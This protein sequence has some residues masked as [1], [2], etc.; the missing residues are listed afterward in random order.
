M[1]NVGTFYSLD[2]ASTKPLAAAHFCTS[3]DLVSHFSIQNANLETSAGE[4]RHFLIHRYSHKIEQPKEDTAEPI[5]ET[6]PP[7]EL[8]DG[9]S[10]VAKTI[11]KKKEQPM[12]ITEESKSQD[13]IIAPVSKAP[14][15]APIQPPVLEPSLDV[16]HSVSVRSASIQ[17]AT[18]SASAQ[19]TLPQPPVLSSFQMGYTES[20]DEIKFLTP[21]DKLISR[22]ADDTDQTLWT[23]I[24][25]SNQDVG[26]LVMFR[27]MLLFGMNRDCSDD[28]LKYVL[29]LT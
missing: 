18:Q 10:V 1:W 22:I 20:E 11:K 7:V 25:R 12:L 15:Q 28:Y 23:N 16:D 6:S 13:P 19:Y 17:S 29:V 2:T 14:L 4:R 5:E 27:E 3:R 21:L 26:N 9:W 8:E 24:S